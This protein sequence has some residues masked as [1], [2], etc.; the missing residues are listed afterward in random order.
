MSG[1][2][3]ISHDEFVALD[4]KAAALLIAARYEALRVRG[5]SAEAAVVV[6]VHPELN[7]DAAAELIRRGCSPRRVLRILL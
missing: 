6:A 1:E 3:G 4:D 5:C 7:V 2:P